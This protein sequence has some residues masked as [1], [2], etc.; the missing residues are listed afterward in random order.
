MVISVLNV[1]LQ[2]TGI[3]LKTVASAVLQELFGMR[4]IQPVYVL[5]VFMAT[6]VKHVQA[7]D[8]GMKN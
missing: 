4:P 3:P 7:Q 1:Q 2:E 6:I 5:L 8:S